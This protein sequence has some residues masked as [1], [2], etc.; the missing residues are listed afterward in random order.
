MNISGLNRRPGFRRT[1]STTLPYFGN[2]PEG[3]FYDQGIGVG[4]SGLQ[5]GDVVLGA[6]IS[7]G[8]TDVA[9]EAASLQSFDG[10]TF[11]KSAEIVVVQ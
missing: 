11:E 5:C 9:E 3:M 10:R 6:G 1:Y 4:G 2:R 7:Q 8:D